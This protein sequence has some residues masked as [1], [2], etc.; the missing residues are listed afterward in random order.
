MSLKNQAMDESFDLVFLHGLR[1][2]VF[3]RMGYHRVPVETLNELIQIL[4]QAANLYILST[5]SPLSD[6]L[7]STVSTP[8]SSSSNVLNKIS[9]PDTKSSS[10]SVSVSDDSQLDIIQGL[11]I[12]LH[13]TANTMVPVRRERFAFACLEIL[14]DLCAFGEKA[15]T[16]TATAGAAGISRMETELRHRTA[17]VA[18]PVLM[19]RCHGLLDAYSA[20]QALL[21]K[22][23][24]PRLRHQE[25]SLVLQRL[26]DLRLVP[27]ILTNNKDA[28]LA[29]QQNTNGNSTPLCKFL[30]LLSRI[31]GS[32]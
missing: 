27:G 28:A 14:F 11:G 24:F 16:T 23:P 6:V 3:F 2:K 26:N 5:R 7:T 20:D 15:T 21:G 9:G 10:V 13:S 25:I 29:T 32:S 22:C 12:T 1:T 30:T 4:D 18:T 31:I 8:R 17:A 19:Q